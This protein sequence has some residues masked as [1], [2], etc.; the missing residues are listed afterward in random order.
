VASSR[1]GLEKAHGTKAVPWLPAS[2][3]GEGVAQG[4][5]NAIANGVQGK[6]GGFG[7]SILDFGLKGAAGLGAGRFLIFD[8]GFWIEQDAAGDAKDREQVTGDRLQ[9]TGDR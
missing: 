2:V 6:S 9:V 8:F 4:N 1:R 5:A 7:F 3:Q